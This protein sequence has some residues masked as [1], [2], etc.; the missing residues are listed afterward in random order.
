MGQMPNFT[1]LAFSPPD[2]YKVTKKVSFPRGG[3]FEPLA[4]SDITQCAQFALEMTLGEGA[5]RAYR[6]NGRH[7]REPGEIFENTLRGKLAE[8]V[9]CN[10]LQVA[11]LNARPDFSVTPLGRWDAGD[12][13]VGGYSLQVKSTKEYG[14]V[15]LFECA[16]WRPPNLYRHG[17][18]GEPLAVDALVMVRVKMPKFPSDLNILSKHAQDVENLTVAKFDADIPGYINWLE[19][20]SCLLSGY[21]L[22][23]ES[24]LNGNPRK[25]D[26][27]NFYVQAGN[28]KPIDLLIN[29]LRKAPRQTQVQA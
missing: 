9:L 19:L 20:E 22:P 27:D 23:S 6:S 3:E 28:L 21:I 10:R 4:Q 12:A 18:A 25:M 17:L 29:G 24:R 15:L 13:Q 7:F 1:P 11:G 5:H 14:N 8:V 16:D 26:V 2:T